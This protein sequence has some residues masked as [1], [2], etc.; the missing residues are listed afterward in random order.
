MFAKVQ[1]IFDIFL[2]QPI[3][4][5]FSNFGNEET[6][7]DLFYLNILIPLLVFLEP[8][9]PIIRSITKYTDSY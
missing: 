9:Y 7:N 3:L 5:D 2:V 8:D 6:S 4:N 1:F